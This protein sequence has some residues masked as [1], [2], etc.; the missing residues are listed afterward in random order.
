MQGRLASSLPRY[1]RSLLA[2]VASYMAGVVE[3]GRLR[4][5]AI[6][7]AQSLEETVHQL[8]QAELEASARLR[9]QQTA[10]SRL[11][12][13]AK[14]VAVGE[15]AAGV[16]HEL[17]NPLTT[18]SGFAELMLDETPVDAPYRAD[19]EMVLHEAHRARSV[20]RRLL[21]FARQGET[22]R[23]TGG[24]QRDRRGRAGADDALH[25]HERRAAGGGA[26]R[27]NCRGSPWTR[28]R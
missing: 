17:N 1:D 7:R 11:V 3:H 24:H 5:E 6:E 14:L 28:T 10:E 12:Q 25:P 16:A 27:A 20:V 9:A 19:L 13:A 2:V 8:R 26:G 21:D 22:A 18:V 23:A 4:A 15:M